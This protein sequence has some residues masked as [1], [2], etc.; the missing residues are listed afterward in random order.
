MEE[1]VFY[2][3]AVAGELSRMVEARLHADHPDRE[4][5]STVLARQREMANTLA[6]PTYVM[7]DP[8]DERVIGV[9]VGPQMDPEKFG[10]WLRTTRVRGGFAEPKVSSAT[11]EGA[12]GAQQPH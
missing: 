6:M 9:H 2:R 7:I 4:Y 8:E 10:E 1:K 11:L 5:K 12:R 3:P